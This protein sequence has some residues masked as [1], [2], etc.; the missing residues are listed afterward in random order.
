MIYT[1]NE[2]SKKCV[3]IFLEYDIQKVYLFGSYTKGN[4]TEDSD[5]DFLIDFENSKLATL[6]DQISLQSK[7]EEIL[8]KEVDI[9]SFYAINNEI[10]THKNPD[11]KSS[12]TKDLVVI[13]DF[14]QRT[15]S[16]K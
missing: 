3:P 10:N 15:T 7:L 14:K 1:I 9:I 8:N 11:F 16:N 13:Y 6:L 4:A 2:I 12:I 5:I